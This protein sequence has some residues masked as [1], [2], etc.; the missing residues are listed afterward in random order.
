MTDRFDFSRNVK[1]TLALTMIALGVIGSILPAHPEPQEFDCL[2][3]PRLRIKLATPVAGVLKN[4][5]VDR[6][7]VIHKGEVLAQL[8]SGVEQASL[9]LAQAKAENDAAIDARQARL[10]FLEKKRR[11]LVV[12]QSKGAASDA[13]RDEA[14]SDYGVAMQELREA[15]ANLEIAKLEVAR[16][17]EVLKQRTIFSPIDGVVAEGNLL[18]GEYAYEQAPI[19]TIAQVNPLNVEVFVPNALYG[20]IQV[21]AQATVRIDEPVGGTYRATVEI[22]DPLIDSRSGTFGIR[23][24]LPNPDNRVPAGLRCKIVFPTQ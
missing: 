13:A 17:A 20:T 18:G 23:L 24:I 8:E 7:A 11:R 12:L 22:I 5:P 15:K 2:L 14:E 6:G 1:V 19:M 21:G 9:A 10:E 3:E 4:V 16:S